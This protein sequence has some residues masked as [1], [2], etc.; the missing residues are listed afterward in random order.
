VS[1]VAG[2]NIMINKV[3]GNNAQ[4]PLEIKCACG[5]LI[6]IIQEF[7]GKITQE[8]KCRKCKKV[9]KFK[10]ITRIAS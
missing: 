10:V 8:I 5:H 3:I 7:E 6:T 2:K 9:I 1:D 4:F